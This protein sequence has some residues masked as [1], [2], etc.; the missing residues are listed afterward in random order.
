MKRKKRFSRRKPRSFSP[1]PVETIVTTRQPPVYSANVLYRGPRYGIDSK[2]FVDDP[3]W[4][5]KVASMINATNPYSRTLCPTKRISNYPTYGKWVVR[6]VPPSNAVSYRTLEGFPGTQGL[7]TM[8][9]YA[10]TPDFD[11]A[12]SEAKL[13]FLS[14]VKKETTPWSGG[15]FLGELKELVRMIK[16]PL[17][18]IFSNAR[19]YRHR[20]ESLLRLYWNQPARLRDQL[21]KFYL[22]WTFGVTPLFSDVKSYLGMTQKLFEDPVVKRISVTIPIIEEVV[23]RST[24]IGSDFGGLIRYMIQNEAKCSGSVQIRGAVKCNLTG[25]SLEKAMS[26]SGFTLAEFIP[27]AYELLP[28]SFLVDY[29]TSIGDVVNGLFTDTSS[30]IWVS[31]TERCLISGNGFC[32]G[33]PGFDAYNLPISFPLIPRAYSLEKLVLNRVKPSLNVGLSDI[34]LTMPS[35]R[36]VFN[37]YVLGIQKMRHL[38]ASSRS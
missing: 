14:K 21:E 4:T 37:T 9:Q 1:R 11:I 20:A 2:T 19:S 28:Y 24:G 5:E 38:D 12:R 10:H 26:L 27:T 16:R 25:P 34:R 36:Q 33:L 30:V 23:G 15:V 18:G 6:R 3:H 7:M 29:F 8:V 35:T 17:G 32:V 22:Q 31:Q 13:A